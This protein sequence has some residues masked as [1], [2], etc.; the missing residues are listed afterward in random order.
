MVK[1]KMAIRSGIKILLFLSILIFG[2]NVW[3][4][5]D[6][7]GYKIWLD[8][9]GSGGGR[10]NSD[11][12]QIDS[13]LTSQ[14]Q[15][16]AQSASF[17]ERFDFAPIA[18]E[19]SIGFSVQSAALNFGE[20]SASSTAYSSHTFSAY[21]NSTSGYTIRVYGEPLKNS[22]YTLAAIG[23][24]P[25]NSLSGTEQFG[26]N[27]VSNSTPVLGADPVGGSGQAAVNYNIVNKYA[28]YE[29][30]VI[31]QASSYTYQTDFTVSVIVNIAD[32]TPAGQYGTTLTY[33]F[34][35]IF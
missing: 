1:L 11:N 17:T 2:R 28:Y 35:P 16:N 27:L 8:T 29:G 23:Q 12:Y 25:E 6:S 33:E 31:A 34:I 13:N 24:V 5:M 4:M 14:T 15:D 3:A 19:P 7:S 18:A 26:I 9:L 30:D 10:I 22:Y 20:L 32:D 21:T